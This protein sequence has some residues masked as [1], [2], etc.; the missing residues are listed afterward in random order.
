MTDDE[1]D[2][3]LDALV[4][5]ALVDRGELIPTTL[6]EVLDTSADDVELPASLALPFDRD[7]KRAPVATRESARPFR[8]IVTVS[9]LA[10]SAAAGWAVFTARHDVAP[11]SSDTTRVERTRPADSAPPVDPRVTVN[12]PAC[13]TECCAG[14]D[15]AAAPSDLSMCPTERTCVACSGLD[16]ADALYRLRFGD[17]FPD[18]ATPQNAA[19]E[20][21]DLCIKVGAGT[22]GEWSCEPAREAPAARPHGRFLKNAVRASELARGVTM[23]LRSGNTVYGRWWSIMKPTARGLCL[24]YRVALTNEK[25]EPV[26][27]LSMFLERAYYVELARSDRESDIDAALKSFS[28]NGVYPQ[29]MTAGSRHVLALGPF[30]RAEADRVLDEISKAAPLPLAHGARLE[31]GDDYESL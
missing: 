13:T 11:I 12:R 5:R 22:S 7:R 25:K 6:E 4:T 27:K 30:D 8:A 2:A 19:L 18:G 14:S 26:G 20:H 23:E 17:V 28:F 9:F 16:D 10:A 15:C 29:F 21:V 24:G 3:E 1:N 31:N